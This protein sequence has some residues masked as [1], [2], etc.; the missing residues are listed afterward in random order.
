MY[1]IV[2]SNDV[3]FCWE[4]MVFTFSFE[5]GLRGGNYS[6]RILI[7]DTYVIEKLKVAIIQPGT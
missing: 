4:S 7:S 5:M 6:G 2:S 1:D 3:L